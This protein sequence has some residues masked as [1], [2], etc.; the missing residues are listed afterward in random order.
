MEYLVFAAGAVI[1]GLF[2]LWALYDSAKDAHT[3][4]THPERAA[5]VDTEHH[6]IEGSH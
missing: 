2:C 5:I 4:K 1:F 3:R 6:A